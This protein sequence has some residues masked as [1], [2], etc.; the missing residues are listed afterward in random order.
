MSNY[1][2]FIT[3][4]SIALVGPADY[5]SLIKEENLKKINSCDVV[6]RINCGFNLIK[7]HPGILG[8]RTD[9]LYNTLLDDCINGG[10]IDV[11]EISKSGIKHIRTVP[12]SDLKGIATGNEPNINKDETYAKI[13]WLQ[14][15]CN[16]E[17]S[18]VDYKFFNDISRK[19]DCRPTTGVVAIYDIL[20]FNPKSLYVCG[21]SFYLGGVMKGY[22][23]GDKPGGI[24]E[25]R[26]RTE[27][28]EAERAFNS[29]RHVHRNIWK[30]AKD[31]LLSNNKVELD[32]VMMNILMLES[33]NR[34]NYKK[35]L[36]TYTNE[37]SS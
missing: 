27:E 23:G 7:D 25:T 16:I 4:K 12:K 9:F 5:L 2:E 17:T 14:Q 36:E 15:H 24:L 13:Q 3:N 1:S 32:E 37:T 28:E 22:W 34:E 29:T 19:V 10:V 8:T 31:T 18:M 35:I 6:V 21:F 11:Q 30:H 20:N 26:N 33:Y